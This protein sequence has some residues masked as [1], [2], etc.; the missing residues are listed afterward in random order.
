MT[1]TT[2]FIAGALTVIVLQLAGTG[3]WVIFHFLRGMRAE[4]QRQRQVIDAIAER[5]RTTAQTPAPLPS[6]PPVLF[7][8]NNTMN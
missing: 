3:I 1:P 8:G 4:R 5:V 7:P 2:A 6:N